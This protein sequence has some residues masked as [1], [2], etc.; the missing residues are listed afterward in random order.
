MLRAARAILGS[1]DLAWDAVQETLLRV[2]RLGWPE[3]EPGAALRRLARLSALHIARC[4]TRRRFHEDRVSGAEPCCAD[5][6]LTE[7]ASTEARG[8]LLAALARITGRYRE[9]FELYELQGWNYRRIAVALAVPVGT[10]RSRLARARRELR[11]KL[12]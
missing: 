1:D 4:R 12:R 7:T 6:P 11:G 5:D 3:S 8:D 10:V 9:V 2:W